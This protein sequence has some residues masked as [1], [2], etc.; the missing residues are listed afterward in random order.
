MDSAPLESHPHAAATN[1][2][3]CRH[4]N[5]CEKQATRDGHHRLKREI[6]D[7]TS[8]LTTKATPF[9]LSLSLSLSTYSDRSTTS[10]EYVIAR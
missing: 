8:G 10:A 4:V 3:R 6:K 5:V 7:V 1:R 9:S 2:P